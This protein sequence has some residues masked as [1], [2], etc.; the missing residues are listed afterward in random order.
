[1]EAIAARKTGGWR[2]RQGGGGKGSL[3]AAKKHEVAAGSSGRASPG[4]TSV[5]QQHIH[6]SK[7]A[8]KQHETTEAKEAQVSH[9]P[10]L[11]GPHYLCALR[12]VDGVYTC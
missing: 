11:S 3:P 2:H 4:T 10:P 6:Q 1:M 5:S 8:E 9:A 12:D 7:A